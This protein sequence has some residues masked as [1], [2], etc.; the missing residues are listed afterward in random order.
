MADSVKLHVAI[1]LRGLQQDLESVQLGLGPAAGRAVRSTAEIVAG[2]TPALTP[3]DPG[4]RADRK[5]HLPHLAETYA[6]A[7]ISATA[8]AITTSHPGG[9]VHE[10]GG[11]IAPKGKAITIE[12]SAMAHRAFDQQADRAEENLARNV[13]RLLTE[14]HLL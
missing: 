12:A 10:Y 14:N 6:T 9:P 4:H 11:T 3:V 2:A 5:D 13:D 7:T 8:A 1:D